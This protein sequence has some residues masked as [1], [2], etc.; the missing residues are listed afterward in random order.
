M[1]QSPE[2]YAMYQLRGGIN[3]IAASP[4]MGHYTA[5]VGTDHGYLLYDDEKVSAT[6]N[7][8]ETSL[9]LQA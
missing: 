8:G 1:R 9:S 7:A 2:D 4:V 6:K 5:V 3:H